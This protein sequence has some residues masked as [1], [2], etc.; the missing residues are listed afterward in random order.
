MITWTLSLAILSAVAGFAIAFVVLARIS[1][2]GLLFG[3]VAVVIMA[4]FYAWIVIIAAIQADE[5]TIV[6]HRDR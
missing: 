2:P 3:I 6:Y 1:N 5:K 4:C